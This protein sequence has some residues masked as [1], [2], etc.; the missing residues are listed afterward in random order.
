M[1]HTKPETVCIAI[2]RPDGGVAIMQFVT[3]D[4]HG[5]SR[6]APPENIEAE[7]KKSGTPCASWRIIDPAEIPNDRTFRNAWKDVGDKIDH[8]M[9]RAREIH[10][11]R[12]RAVRNARLAETDVQVT[13]AL[14]A[15]Q[16]TKEIAA[17][18][19]ALRGL[20]QTFD[21][22]KCATV[23]ELKAAWPEQLK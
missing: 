9:A 5:M 21:I 23:E 2:A 20:P 8:D 3:R 14:E 7:I 22:S 19:R 6:E 11:D 16:D 15:G 13:R 4:A 17:K 10:M 1:T 12:I 18:R